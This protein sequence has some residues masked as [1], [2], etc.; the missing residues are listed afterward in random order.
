MNTS[1]ILSLV[2]IMNTWEQAVVL[3]C[4][5]SAVAVLYICQFLTVFAPGVWEN[6]GNCLNTKRM[7]HLLFN[8][9]HKSPWFGVKIFFL[10]LYSEEDIGVEGYKLHSCE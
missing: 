9:E 7:L 1:S 5:V 3:K 10:L 6:S 4:V 8:P 2:P